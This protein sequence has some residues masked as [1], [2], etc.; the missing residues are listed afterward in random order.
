MRLFS[1]IILLFVMNTISIGQTQFYVPLRITDSLRVGSGSIWYGVHPNASY[2]IP[3]TV[4]FTDGKIF[5]EQEEP[6]PPP[7]AIYDIRFVNNSF[8]PDTCLGQGVAADIRKYT[9]PNQIDTFNIRLQL[10]SGI[11]PFIFSWPAG[12]NAVCDSMKLFE[13]I[14]GLTFFNANMLTS[15][16]YRLTLPLNSARIIKYGAK[17][18][19]A[20]PPVATPLYRPGNGTINVFAKPV[21]FEWDGAYGALQYF[22]EIASD[23]NFSN[24]VRIDTVNI[25]TQ[26]P[27]NPGTAIA[28]DLNYQTKYFWRV[29]SKN[30]YGISPYSV[31]YSFTT[32]MPVVP[33][34]P[35]LVYPDSGLGNVSKSPL[36]K[37]RITDRADR[38][39][40]I[41]ATDTGFT[42]SNIVFNDSTNVDTSKQIGPLKGGTVYYWKVRARNISGY[43]AYSSR[44]FFTTILPV[45]PIPTLL[46]PANN[47]TALAINPTLSW[48]V[49]EDAQF[50]HLQVATDENFNTIVTQ[51]STITANL[52]QVSLNNFTTYYWRV[53]AKN[54]TGSSSFSSVWQF[55]TIIAIPA[56][57]VL[58]IPAN[59]DTNITL[60]PTLV[61]N[62]LQYAATYELNVASDQNFTT[63]VYTISNLN[64]TSQQVTALESDKIFYWRVRATNYAGTGLYSDVWNF[65]TVL[66][67][68]EKVTLISPLNNAI[69]IIANPTIQWSSAIRGVRYHYQVDTIITFPDPLFE[70]SSYAGLSKQIGPLDLD[71]KYYWRVRSWNRTGYGVYSDIYNFI[72]VGLPKPAIPELRE[73]RN[74]APNISLNP[75]LQWD[76][77]LNA[78]VYFLEVAR[79]SIFSLANR[80]LLDT[81]VTTI[82]RKIGL[83]SE[84]TKYFWRVKA[85]NKAGMSEWSIGWSFRTYG[86]EPANWL[87]SFVVFETGIARDTIRFGV[88]PNATHGI[89]NSLGEYMLPPVEPGYFDAR[90]V[91]PPRRAGILGEGLRLNYLPFTNFTQIDTYKVSFQTGTGSYPVTIR[92][93]NLFF[94]NVCDSIKLRDEIGGFTVNIRMDIDNSV[95]I[96]NEAVK[97]L[98][99]TKWGA[100]PLNVK[101]ESNKIPDDFVLYQN[102]PNPFNPTT[103][104]RFS[105]KS[106]SRASLTIYNALGEYI[107]TLTDNFFIPGIYSIDWDATD[108]NKQ[109]VPSGVYFVR[110]NSEKYSAVQKMIYLR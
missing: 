2:C 29:R 89:D 50:Y 41:V 31:I 90:W 94:K 15:T 30:N 24:I 48:S 21:L 52:K 98:L 93:N 10:G 62:A 4:T 33:P 36:M 25:T 27:F 42:P 20:T 23:T 14:S 87:T 104:I 88:H 100:R 107:T 106:S 70:D 13:E 103:N 84:K 73:P 44:F 11:R 49:S 69:D 105:I 7:S 18:A 1:I 108:L 99:L 110:M 65:K 81:T 91:S 61:W 17:P 19:P 75:T 56:K 60:T 96:T 28:K 37:W 77:A 78:D 92:W 39:H 83:L 12:L 101:I 3:D 63:I 66:T 57:P 38:Y 26:A 34:A 53:K 16:R 74:L 8:G 54:A 47:D 79:D 58:S 72:T 32:A 82:E 85:K 6:P 43:G 67:P 59:N 22:L 40:F 71:K 68:P 55:K 80:V 76:V 95:Q 64:S 5:R 86:D 9:N 45:P 35:K 51:D 102:Y 97:T 109:N 46:S